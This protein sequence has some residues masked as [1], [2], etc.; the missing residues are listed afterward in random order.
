[1][2][3][4]IFFSSIE[5][6]NDPFETLFSIKSWNND[7]LGEEYFYKRIFPHTALSRIEKQHHN[8]IINSRRN[9][10]AKDIMLNHDL[11]NS[12]L[13]IL[14][15]LFGVACFSSTYDELLMWSHYGD[16]GKGVCLIFDKEILFNKNKE[17][18][19]KIEKVSYIEKLPSIDVHLT[20]TRI[21]FDTTPIITSKRKNWSYEKEVRAFI[22]FGKLNPQ[23]QSSSAL[24]NGKDKSLRNLKF[25][26]KAF[27]GL[28]F[29]HNCTVECR[30]NLKT[31]LRS[32]EYIDFDSLIF[33]EATI[34]THTGQYL[35]KREQSDIN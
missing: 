1:M 20:E 4:T 6:F 34:N 32:N 25:N 28:I 8:E 22:D 30:D 27:K 23:I 9:D 18:Y 29:G 3:N 12:I 26:S 31:I 17:G 15:D 19:P 21:H 24:L 10:P 2:N 16:I 5:D 33:A 7:I 35:F 13:A 11:R 14:R